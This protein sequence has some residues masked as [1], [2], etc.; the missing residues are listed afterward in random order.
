MI[1]WLIDKL[2][3]LNSKFRLFTA[4]TFRILFE[5]FCTIS[6]ESQKDRYWFYMSGKWMVLVYSL[7]SWTKYFG[8]EVKGHLRFTTF[9]FFLWMFVSSAMQ[10]II[11]F[12][13]KTFAFETKFYFEIQVLSPLIPI[14]LLSQKFKNMFFKLQIIL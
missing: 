4:F 2:I 7:R 9:G 10:S 11:N 3:E 12:A 1:S 14:D 8:I 5:S 13:R 6:N